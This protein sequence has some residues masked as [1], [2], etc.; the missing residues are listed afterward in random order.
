[1]NLENC[2][3]VLQNRPGKRKYFSATGL[4]ILKFD[5]KYLQWSSYFVKQKLVGLL[6]MDSITKVFWN[7]ATN[8]RLYKIISF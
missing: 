7:I 3:L 6:K 1:M 2:S 5:I 8:E 4:K